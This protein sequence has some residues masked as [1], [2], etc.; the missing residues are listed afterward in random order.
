M[1]EPIIFARIGW[2]KFYEGERDDDPRPIGGGSYNKDHAGAE[3]RNF[4]VR[5]HGQVFGFVHTGMKHKLD[6]LN[7]KRI[8]PTVETAAGLLHGIQVVFLA[9]IPPAYQAELGHGT[10]VVGWY[11]NAT[12]YDRAE[13]GGDNPEESYYN[14]TTHEDDATLV[15][16][17]ERKPFHLSGKGGIGQTNIRYPFSENGE[18]ISRER[19]TLS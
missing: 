6:G 18:S 12:A 9:T 15:P 8:D 19:M 2:M 4:L 11:K 1:V 17:E 5:E 7:L 10:C 16:Y 3:L 13:H 14:L